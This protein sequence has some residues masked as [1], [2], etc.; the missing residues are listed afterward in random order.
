MFYT[1][2]SL[3]VEGSKLLKA[4]GVKKFLQLDCRR[5][6]S[7]SGRNLLFTRLLFKGFQI[8]FLKGF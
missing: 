7:K 3:I 1:P 2:G 4:A 6:F 8:F 5:G